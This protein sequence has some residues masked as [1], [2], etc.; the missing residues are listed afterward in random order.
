MRSAASPVLEL[1][2]ATGSTGELA[3]CTLSLEA[4]T[5]TLLKGASSSGRAALLRLLGLLDV[6]LAGE[7]MLLGKP[8][9]GLAEPVRENLRNQHCGYLFAA[10]FLL[11]NL[12]IVENVAVPLFRISHPTSESAHVRTTAL[13][14][15]VGLEHAAEDAIDTL[16]LPQQ[17]AVSLARALANEPAVIIVEDILH[18]A[19][20]ALV[21]LLR[22]AAEQ[23]GVAVIAAAPLD[24]TGETADHVL[25]LAA[26][27]L[28]VELCPKPQPIL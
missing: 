3:P 10:P 7:V 27:K 8:T 25:E 13:L 26:G 21:A 4:G 28:R 16:T 23:F 20:P 5:F 12:S 2:G 11:P 24:F 15:F 18:E 9:A 6:P 17:H 22:R 14:D 1:R 19:G